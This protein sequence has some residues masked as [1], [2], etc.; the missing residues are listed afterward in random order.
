MEYG[1]G[2]PTRRL[3]GSSS[4]CQVAVRHSRRACPVFQ[5]GYTPNAEAARN[6]HPVFGPET[7]RLSKNSDKSKI[8]L[9]F[10]QTTC[11]LRHAR[12]KVEISQS[13]NSL[14]STF[15]NVVRPSVSICSRSLTS[16]IPLRLE[17]SGPRDWID[18][19]P[20][21]S[22][23][24][25]VKKPTINSEICVCEYARRRSTP[26]SACASTHVRKREVRSSNS[27]SESN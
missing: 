25:E 14:K 26:K 22:G 12:F 4:R 17:A 16:K 2:N 8:T 19:C 9:P 1:L 27:H 3:R 10:F 18:Q 13:R 15:P 24:Q 7:W 20:L 6:S 23:A 11:R 21:K 5:G